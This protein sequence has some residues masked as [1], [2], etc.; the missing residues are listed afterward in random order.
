MEKFPGG[1]V[2]SKG[3]RGNLEGNSPFSLENGTE[4]LTA[5]FSSVT[6]HSYDDALVVT[7]TEPLVAF[8]LS[9][10]AKEYLSEGQIQTLRE[11]I[12]QE[13]ATNGS[14]YITKASGLF[15]AIKDA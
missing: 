14:I 5:Y 6:L 11:N 12:E 3:F 4:Q 7:E 15:E 9:S 8:I 13:I 2:I 10:R 1:E